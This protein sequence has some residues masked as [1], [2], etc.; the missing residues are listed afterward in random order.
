MMER[1]LKRLD[2]NEEGNALSGSILLRSIFPE[3]DFWSLGRNA[4]KLF[5]T[6]T[7]HQSRG[8][9]KTL[10]DLFELLKKACLDG[11]SNQTTERAE[12]VKEG[13]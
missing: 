12:R 1:V 2:S 13:K 10:A 9:R 6:R 8:E 3:R 4:L 5:P 7:V 11:N